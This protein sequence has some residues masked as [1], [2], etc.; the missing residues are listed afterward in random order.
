MFC[1]LTPHLGPKSSRDTGKVGKGWLLGGIAGRYL[2]VSGRQPVA[3]CRGS[4]DGAPG[5]G[6]APVRDVW[7]GWA[8]READPCRVPS[9]AEGACRAA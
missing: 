5:G 9:T 4:W 6:N 3:P 7:V 2:C 8:T 1:Y